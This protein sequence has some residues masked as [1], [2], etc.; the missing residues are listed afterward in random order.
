[1]SK[2]NTHDTDLQHDEDTMH[3][4]AMS[5]DQQDD[6]VVPEPD[7]VQSGVP[8]S[9]RDQFKEGAADG[10]SQPVKDYDDY[11]DYET[12]MRHAGFK[13]RRSTGMSIRKKLNFGLGTLIAVI[14]V[15]GFVALNSLNTINNS[16]SIASDQTKLA[17]VTEE[18]KA[19]IF[20]IRDAEKDFLLLEEQTS[21]DRVSRY[22]AKVRN[23]LAEAKAIGE[24]IEQN[25]GIQVGSRF[26]SMSDKVDNYENNFAVQIKDVQHAREMLDSEQLLNQKNRDKLSANIEDSIQQVRQLSTDFWI[27]TRKTTG[28]ELIDAG[29]KLDTI[30]SNMQEIR[31]I[32]ANFFSTGNSAY[33]D[34]ARTEITDTITLIDSL[35]NATDD[36]YIRQGMVDMRKAMLLYAGLLR[37]SSDDM[38]NSERKKDIIDERIENQKTGLRDIGND[39]IGMAIELSDNSWETIANENQRLTETSDSTQ[40]FLL[41]VVIGGIAIGIIVLI[42]VPRPIIN[43][44]NGLLSGAKMV[45]EGNLTTSVRISNNDELGELANTFNHMRENLLALVKRIQRASVQLSSSINEIQ[46]A[47][48]QQSSAANEQ[49]SAVNE[50][51]SSLTQ[52]SQTA[53]TLVNS[54]ETVNR[55]VSDIANTINDS[56]SKSSA[57]MLSMDVIGLSTSQTADRIKALNDKM[58]DINDAVGT[59]SLVAD[60][61][62]LLSLNASIEANK[63]GEMGKGF[64][65]VANEIRRLSDRSIDSATSISSMVRDIQRATEN[66][67]V[68]MDKSSK[69]IKDGIEQV[70]DSTYALNMINDS[71]DHIQEQM[72]MILDSVRTHAGSSSSVQTTAN[73]LLSSANMV[74]QA[75][76]QTQKITFELN[77]MA[78]QLA[79]AVSAFRL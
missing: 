60:Q 65:V 79:A 11:D 28:A 20:N 53:T 6:F 76:T 9:R 49:A 36:E 31:I 45:A 10:A 72:S 37:S 8:F 51:S 73:E 77:A 27:N 39:V 48:T 33:A 41:L 64:S 58:D 57:M 16:N 32:I 38:L 40:W 14:A 13:S 46:A 68:A 55:N 23:Q 22:T 67:T 4:E 62:T 25:S 3:N 35:R 42:V 56:N 26:D 24:R 19:T 63:A 75:A 5:T 70:K 30:K 34:A 47:A 61:T 52:M 12:D 54:S 71:M 50:L 1:M 44:I 18:I 17:K 74:S 43:G 69:E 66:S 2:D 78:T 15:L 29:I 21:L 7:G 59:I